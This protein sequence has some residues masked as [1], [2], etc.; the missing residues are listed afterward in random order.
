MS[1]P[2][3]SRTLIVTGGNLGAWALD[4]LS[5]YTT[6][7]G[8]DRGAEFIARHGYRMRVAVGDF[9][10]IADGQLQAIRDAADEV[11]SFDA[12]DKDWSDTELA[13]REAVNRGLRDIDMIGALGTRFDHSLANVH[14][15]KQAQELGCSLRLIDDHNEISLCEHT[16]RL[17]VD[18]RYPY[19]SLLPLT[20][21]VTGITLQGFLYPLNDA[22]IRIG[23][24]IGISNVL[25]QPS[26]TVTIAS[27]LLL[28]IR[29]R[30]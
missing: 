12:I 5:D 18:S 25:D 9:D 26:G 14:L 13:F 15:L 4:R 6:L 2:A 17:T 11:I 7:I 23:Q 29:S 1:V 16:V 10:S 19:V 22:T 30:D 8:A 24:S 27:G 28:V 21:A 20:E 3:H